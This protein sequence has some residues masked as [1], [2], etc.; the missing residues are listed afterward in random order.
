[1]SNLCLISFAFP[2]EFQNQ[3]ANFYRKMRTLNKNVKLCV[4]LSSQTILEIKTH[5]FFLA[6]IP[7]K[8]SVF[9][10]QKSI[11]S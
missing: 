7:G 4:N 8:S 9:D 11:K 3:F 10:M 6:V 2:Y 5:F 1:M